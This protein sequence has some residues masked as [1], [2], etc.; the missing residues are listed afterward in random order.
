MSACQKESNWQLVK[1]IDLE[2]ITPIGLAIEGDD[3]W[4]ADG[5]NNRVVN[6][7]T[8]GKIKKAYD[9]FERPM[10]LAIKENK[11]FIPEYGADQ[12]IQFDGK[13]KTPLVLTDS[14]DAPAGVSLWENE[15]AIADF[16][17]H[18][19]VFFNGTE[20]IFFGKEG[21]KEGLFYYPTDVELT[22]D[23]IFVADAYNNRVQVFD[24]KGQFIQVVGSTDGINAATGLAVS[25]TQLFVTDFENDR[26]LIYDLKGTLQQIIDEGL[27]KP[28]D[29]FINENWLY[30]A[31]Y[32]GKNLMI[33][34]L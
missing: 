4:I 16:Y 25:E 24:K 9:G 8:D 17:N 23:K 7:S 10:H 29:V 2:T 26:V 13:T 20:T 19:I 1:T 30:I 34:Q 21:K 15:Y 27:E 3:L 14:L 33:Y 32:K 22:K 5:D 28:T 11:V 31:N 18:R 6:L 12:I